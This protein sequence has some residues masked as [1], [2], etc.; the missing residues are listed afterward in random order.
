MLH[1]VIT[2]LEKRGLHWIAVP[3]IIN[4]GLAG[5]WGRGEGGSGSFEVA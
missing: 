1:C 4:V 5:G 3:V 2:V